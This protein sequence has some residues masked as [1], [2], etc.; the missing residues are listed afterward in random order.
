M[1]AKVKG[2]RKLTGQLL[3]IEPQVRARVA[4]ELVR[5]VDSLVAYQ[6]S[7]API[8][9]GYGNVQGGFADQFTRFAQIVPG[10]GQEAFAAA[11]L[12][13]RQAMTIRVRQDTETRSI[14]PEWRATDVTSGAAYNIRAV[15]DPYLGG[16]DHGRW[17]DCEAESG[18]AV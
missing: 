17:I 13:G 4:E 1:A 8:D 2:V 18:V 5:Q 9:D 7:Q 12:E 6:Q 3:A 16:P 15:I 14:R 10:R 11:A